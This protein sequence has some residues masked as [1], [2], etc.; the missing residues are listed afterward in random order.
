MAKGTSPY[1]D[2]NRKE[3]VPLSQTTGSMRRE[4]IRRVSQ[5]TALQGWADGRSSS[6]LSGRSLV[7]GGILGA[8]VSKEGR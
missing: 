8:E 6:R 2:G 5:V 3:G 1:E 4:E 7:L